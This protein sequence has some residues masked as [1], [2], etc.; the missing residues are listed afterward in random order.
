MAVKLL[1]KRQV[2]F[3]GL[4]YLEGEMLANEDFAE[5]IMHVY[6]NAVVLKHTP[7]KEAPAREPKT[8]PVELEKAIALEELTDKELLQLAQDAGIPASYRWKRETI[9]EHL[10]KSG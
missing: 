4:T 7:K 10:E 2:T 1:V 5:R 6:P 8:V 9:L 3:E